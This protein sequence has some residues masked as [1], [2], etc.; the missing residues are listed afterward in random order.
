MPNRYYELDFERTVELAESAVKNIGYSVEH[1]Y[2]YVGVVEAV[3][4][5]V[6]TQGLCDCGQWNGVPIQG[7]ASSRFLI[8]INKISK[9]KTQVA[10]VLQFGTHFKARNRM[11]MVTREETYLCASTGE[12]ENRYFA[13]LDQL[14]AD[15]AK[16][17][18]KQPSSPDKDTGLGKATAA[19]K[20]EPK[21]DAVAAGGQ[22]P[23][24]PRLE[25]LKGLRAKGLISEA[26]FEAEAAKLKA[27]Q[28]Q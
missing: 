4:Q 25:R 5:P 23:D 9:D 17:G 18:D 10:M 11:G 8:N 21:P 22:V 27:G 1:T 2:S 7:M 3:P 16:Q 26:E 28:G 12:L 14:V 13:A 20:T 19:P 6:N 15:A 24:A